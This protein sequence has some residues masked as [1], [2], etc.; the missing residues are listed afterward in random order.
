MFECSKE[1]GTNLNGFVE[2]DDDL[3]G[4]AAKENHNNRHQQSSHGPIPGNIRKYSTG[5]WIFS[6]IW[7]H[8][9][10]YSHMSEN[11]E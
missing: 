7:S 11:K 3:G 5:P 8:P 6:N 2:V 10:K 4:V 1:S 9:W